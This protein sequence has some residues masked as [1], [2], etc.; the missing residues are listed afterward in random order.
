MS[1]PDWESPDA[2]RHYRD[3]DRADFAQEF[4]RR[5][6]VFVADQERL[7]RS[8]KVGL[9][10]PEA[11]QAQLAGRWGCLWPGP[12]GIAEGIARLLG[13]RS[14]TRA[15]ATLAGTERV[16]DPGRRRRRRFERRSCP[17]PS[18]IRGN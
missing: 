17:R 15:R 10:T 13:I 4:L 14:A 9:I 3:H 5:N 7:A 1:Y 2:K 11:A 18:R 16:A 6:P 12:I 8:V